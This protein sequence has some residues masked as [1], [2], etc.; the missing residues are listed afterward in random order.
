MKKRTLILLYILPF[1]SCGGGGG[2]FK[3]G[4]GSSAEGINYAS[5]NMRVEEAYENLK[6]AL[7]ENDDI[8]V[9]AEVDHGNNAAGTGLELP[10][11]R[12]IFFGNPKAG[13]QL[14]QKDQIAGLDLPLRVL[15]Y[16]NNEEVV[17]LFNSASYM[18]KRYN[19]RNSNTL[20]QISSNLDRLMGDAMGT[21]VV[22]GKSANVRNSQGIKTVQSTRS[23]D[24]TYSSILKILGN[25][26][27]IK[28]IAQ[29]DHSA[30]AASVGMELRPT[31]LIIFGNPSLGTPLMQSA[32]STGLDLP[33]KM[34]VWEDEE[35]TVNI[36]FNTPQFL[37][38]RHNFKGLKTEVETMA[39]GLNDLARA[40][41]GI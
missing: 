18:E 7:G 21:E 10:A 1:I 37:K 38:T 35:G 13:T 9:I 40:A 22:W 30:N 36:S 28:I 27:D 8:S 41:A 26:N 19:L 32:I 4:I 17:A 34:L 14:M 23:F 16:E 2:L 12:I 33:Q 3:G 29:L 25:N 31:K 11:S 5:A 20:Q 15:F 24:E 6:A 39:T